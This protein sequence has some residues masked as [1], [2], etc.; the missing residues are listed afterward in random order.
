MMDIWKFERN[1]V[2]LIPSCPLYMGAKD[3]KQM[4]RLVKPV[5]ANLPAMTNP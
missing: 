5:D 3:L 2:D 4:S 1:S